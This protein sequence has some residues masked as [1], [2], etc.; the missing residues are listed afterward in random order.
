MKSAFVAVVIAALSVVPLG[1]ARSDVLKLS[2][3]RAQFGTKS[4]GTFSMKKV[5][6]TNTSSNAIDLLVSI[7]EMPSDFSYGRLPGSTCPNSRPASL[8]PK[9]SCK[10]VVGFT[11]STLAVGEDQL[12]RLRATATDPATGKVLESVVIEFKGKSKKMRL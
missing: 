2:P 12:A 11:P 3:N 10:A 5:V 8:G 1:T 9:Q 7:D 6:I 4:V